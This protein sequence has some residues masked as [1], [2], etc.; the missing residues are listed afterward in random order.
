ME[1]VKLRNLEIPQQVLVP[2]KTNTALD[3]FISDRGGLL[4]SCIYVVVGGAG[5]GKT[6]WSIDTIHKLQN[7]N[8]DKKFLYISGEQDEIDNYELS[9]KLPGLADLSTLYLAGCQDPKKVLTDVLEQGWDC[10]LMDSL[11]VVASRIRTTTGM[12]QK[13]SSTWVMDLMFKHKKG[14]NPSNIFT[15]FMVIQQATKGGNFKG[16]SSIEFDTTG[17][18]YVRYDED[19]GNRYLSFSK[20]RRG[21]NKIRQYYRL[22]NGRMQYIP[23]VT[24]T[25]FVAQEEIVSDRK[26]RDY[27]HS[28][29]TR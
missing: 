5:S 23:R 3:S 9:Q 21:S 26:P 15:T 13:E 19:E 24:Q 2:M 22:S 4:P 8:P 6:S 12:N 25:T 11:E 16:D 28:F 7:T 10:V 29:L 14:G 27:R 20:N 1:I 17:M 18:L